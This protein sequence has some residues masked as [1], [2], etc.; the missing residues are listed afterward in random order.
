MVGNF[1]IAEFGARRPW[2]LVHG[3]GL[4]IVLA[5]SFQTWRQLRIW[6]VDQREPRHNLTLQRRTA[7]RASIPLAKRGAERVEK[8]ITEGAIEDY[9]QALKLYPGHAEAHNNLALLLAIRGNFDEAIEHYRAALRAKPDYPLAYKNLG[10]VLLVQGKVDEAIASYRRALELDPELP[11]AQRR[12][13]E[14]LYGSDKRSARQ[15]VDDQIRSMYKNSAPLAQRGDEHARHGDL[16]GAIEDYQAALRIYPMYPEVHNNIGLLLASE[17]KYIEAIEHYRE[18][19]RLNPEFPLAYTNLG[20]ALLIQGKNDEAIDCF[21]RA[22][23]LDPKLDSAR[24]SLDK[25]LRANEPESL[26]HFSTDVGQ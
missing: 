12:L 20:D 4:T 18:A 23:K 10:D 19:L 16:K 9:L 7:Q 3:L 22:L 5:L 2:I 26:L 15:I 6:A 8:G 1:S 14:A 24:Q 25:A 11:A 17:G 13:R 21:R